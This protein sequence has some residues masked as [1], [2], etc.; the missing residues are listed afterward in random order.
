MNITVYFIQY[1][2]EESFHERAGDSESEKSAPI[3]LCV[4]HVK[5]NNSKG[6]M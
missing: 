5:K 2:V 4:L 3:K 1:L 6:N